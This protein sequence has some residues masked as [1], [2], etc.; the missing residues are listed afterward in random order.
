MSSST[1][2]TNKANNILVL[3]KDFIQGINN[4]KIYAEKMYSINFS[5][6]ERRLWLSLHYNGG[7]SY[8]AVDGREMI[9]FKTK[10]SEIVANRLC[11]G[12]ISKDFS[13][14]NMKKTGLH[15]SIY[16]FSIDHKVVKVDGKL[17]YRK[18]LTKK[19]NIV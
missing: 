1:H 6:T 3:G 5:T 16:D 17:E 2:A 8:L 7:N 18:Y 10:D 14:S 13:E 9:K 12:N 11:L 4:T 15:G 19:H